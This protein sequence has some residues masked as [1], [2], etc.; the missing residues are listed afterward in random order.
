M[1]EE[2]MRSVLLDLVL[3]AWEC[4]GWGQAWMQRPQDSGVRDLTWKKQ[5]NK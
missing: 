5:G 3:T 2:L 1:V 4:E